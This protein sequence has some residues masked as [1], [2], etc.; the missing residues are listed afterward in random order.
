[1]LSRAVDTTYQT[2]EPRG[3]SPCQKG[4]P[5]A[6]SGQERGLIGFLDIHT[7]MLVV[8]TVEMVRE[9]AVG[10][11]GAVGNKYLDA[12]QDCTFGSSSE[13]PHFY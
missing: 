7:M 8:L 12:C 11:V 2:P 10:L 1:V 5:D 4:S 13:P 9:R 6:S 3:P